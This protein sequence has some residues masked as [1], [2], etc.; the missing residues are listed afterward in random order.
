M[1]PVS[2]FTVR[3]LETGADVTGHIAVMH[4]GVHFTF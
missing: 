2:E 1:S 3:I 4:L